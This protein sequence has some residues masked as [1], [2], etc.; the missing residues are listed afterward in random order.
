MPDIIAAV[1]SASV[2][3][4]VIPSIDLG[5]DSGFVSGVGSDVGSRV[6]WVLVSTVLVQVSW[7]WVCV[8]ESDIGSGLGPDDYLRS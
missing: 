5:T 8:Q 3:F 7:V 4:G 1:S 6:T 2:S